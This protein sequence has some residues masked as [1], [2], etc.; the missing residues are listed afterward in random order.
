MRKASRIEPMWC[1]V[2]TVRLLMFVDP[3]LGQ[4]DRQGWGIKV[5]SL[6]VVEKKGASEGLCIYM[7]IKNAD[8]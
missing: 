2:E 1:S 5:F 6:L 7:V 8:M 4:Q 3:K